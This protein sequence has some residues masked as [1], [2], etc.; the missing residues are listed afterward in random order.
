M[1]TPNNVGSNSNSSSGVSSIDSCASNSPS[2]PKS[3]ASTTYSVDGHLEQPSGL[4]THNHDHH[5]NN[6]GS[7]DGGFVSGASASS[8]SGTTDSGALCVSADCCGAGR[9]H[10]DD[11]LEEEE[12]EESSSDEDQDDDDDEETSDDEP[13][14][15]II[16]Q[17]EEIQLQSHSIRNVRQ[18]VLD[19]F[20]ASSEQYFTLDLVDINGMADGKFG[21]PIVSSSS[22]Q[23]IKEGGCVWLFSGGDGLQ[24]GRPLIGVNDVFVSSSTSS[25][26]NN[27]NNNDAS[28]INQNL[29]HVDTESSLLAI[30]DMTSRRQQSPPKAVVD[31]SP[32]QPAMDRNKE[33]KYIVLILYLVYRNVIHSFCNVFKFV[34]I[35][36]NKSE[37]KAILKPGKSNVNSELFRPIKLLCIAY[38]LLEKIIYKKNMILVNEFQLNKPGFV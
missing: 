35:I 32:L 14:D 28:N 1:L 26:P 9:K 2:P 29:S 20:N 15:T 3:E 22:G 5:D 19:F 34:V 17:P 31:S 4:Q 13:P 6:P 36:W 12:D 18:E 16:D 33:C 25:N 38:I 27:N 10:E 8:P 11:E 37:I 24:A 23:P 7:V 30:D 21:S